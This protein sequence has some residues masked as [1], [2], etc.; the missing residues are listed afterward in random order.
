MSEGRWRH[1][2]EAFDPRRMRL[3]HASMREVLGTVPFALLALAMTIIVARGCH[4]ADV[5]HLKTPAEITSRP[6]VTTTSLVDP[7]GI[8]LAPVDGVTTTRPAIQT[9]QASIGGSVSSPQG[10]APGAIVRIERIA[11]GGQVVDVATD[12]EG[13]WAIGGIAGGRYR[14]RA[15]LPPKLAQPTAEVFFLADGEEH[16]LNLQLQT[17]DGAAVAGAVA[18]DPPAL[19][20]LFA[21]A[22]RVAN[23]TVDANG[24]GRSVPVPGATVTITSAGGNQVQGGSAATAD[25][26][27]SVTF[28]LLC[29][30]TTATQVLV[31]VKTSPTDPGQAGAIEVPACTPPPTVPPSSSAPTSASSGPSTTAAPTTTTAN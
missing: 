23:R 5:P 3:P 14:V 27:G 24:D 10:P 6:A 18:P 19:N 31:Q 15:F 4:T 30:A 21:L 16:L 12:A 1:L 7:R 29:K 28:T 13:K 8:T 25:G 22:I 20:Q 26:S 2:G 17:F 11:Q 9:G